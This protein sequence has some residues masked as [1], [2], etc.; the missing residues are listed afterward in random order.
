MTGAILLLASH[1]RLPRRSSRCSVGRQTRRM[2]ACEPSSTVACGWRGLTSSRHR[3]WTQLH[4]MVMDGPISLSFLFS[5]GRKFKAGTMAGSV[6]ASASLLTANGGGPSAV[7]SSGGV[8]EGAG[9]GAIS[10]GAQHIATGHSGPPRR[11]PSSR[12]IS[13]QTDLAAAA[14]T[15][16][17]YIEQLQ[18]ALQQA[19]VSSLQ[20]RLAERMKVHQQHPSVMAGSSSVAV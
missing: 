10:S 1:F 12:A 16:G 19:S 9:G 2:S 5:L 17:Q 4:L 15:D 7:I 14:L 6:V 11:R 20:E 18:S 8:A 13:G 3:S